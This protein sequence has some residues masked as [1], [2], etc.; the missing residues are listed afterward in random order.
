MCA[1]LRFL[2]PIVLDRTVRLSENR[3]LHATLRRGE[4][5]ILRLLPHCAVNGL[6]LSELRAF[7]AVRWKLVSQ[8]RKLAGV[9]SYVF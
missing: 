3:S 7:R 2:G 4:G 9:F 8:S 6:S 5:L 1:D